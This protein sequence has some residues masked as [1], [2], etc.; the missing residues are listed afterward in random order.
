MLDRQKTIEE[1]KKKGIFHLNKTVEI[2]LVPQKIAVLSAIDSKGFE[3]FM[4][5]LKNNQYGYGF[6]VHLFSVVLQGNK[7][8]ETIAEQLEYIGQNKDKYD[9]IAI[10]RGGGGNVDLQCY[11]SYTLSEA[12]TLSPLPIITG[13]GHTTDISVTDEVAC[14]HKETP[15]AVAQH[16]IQ[17]MQQY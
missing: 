13:I 6:N 16:I 12:V 4:S 5:V 10:V 17:M 3:D 7:A 11:N 9:I 2:P 1:L 8:A 14:I 15:T